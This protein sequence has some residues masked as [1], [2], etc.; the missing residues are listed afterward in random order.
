[1]EVGASGEGFACAKYSVRVFTTVEAPREGPFG[2]PEAAAEA[3]RGQVLPQI[4][5]DW[6][7]CVLPCLSSVGCEKC[8]SLGDVSTWRILRFSPLNFYSESVH[9]FCVAT[10]ETTFW[11]AA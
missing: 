11:E 3:E 5:L 8:Q 2:T 7:R 9:G 10:F 4:R 1:M 6:E